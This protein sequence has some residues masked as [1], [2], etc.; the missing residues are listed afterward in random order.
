M[1]NWRE[2]EALLE[3][4]LTGE[5]V[6]DRAWEAYQDRVAI[7]VTDLSGFTRLTRSL[8]SPK[9]LALLME[10]RR[11]A[12]PVLK[13]QG[14]I[15][16]K[17]QAD[18]LFAAFKDPAAAVR[19]AVELRKTFTAPRHFLPTNVKL[20]MGIGFGDVLWWGEED[21]YGEEV[22]LASKLGEDV[23]SPNE[24]LLTAAAAAESLRLDASLPLVTAGTLTV[25]G[26]RY[27]YY[28]LVGEAREASPIEPG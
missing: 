12:V 6:P 1:R 16:V 9:T 14:G 15:P 2:F 5:V 8:G 20:C 21:L 24:I 13:S 7:L 23:A 3:K 17:Y 27:E 26:V 19:A 28:R 11:V 10:M 4:V 22:N 25:G 18:D